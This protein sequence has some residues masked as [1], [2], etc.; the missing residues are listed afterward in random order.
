[1]DEGQ[2]QA[3]GHHVGSG[4][5][6]VQTA[7]NPN[8]NLKYKINCAHIS[9][10]KYSFLP[11]DE[12]SANFKTLTTNFDVLVYDDTCIMCY[13]VSAVIHRYTEEEQS[14]LL[15]QAA[16]A[17][18]WSIAAAAANDNS[19]TSTGGSFSSTINPT[20]VLSALDFN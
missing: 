7:P 3:M 6:Q 2:A 19:T 8:T 13:Q 18:W 1:M 16:E 14:S 15:V 20:P 9:I 11:I 5:F 17:C 4:V 10:F 12:S